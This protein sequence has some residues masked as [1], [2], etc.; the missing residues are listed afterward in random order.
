MC[1]WIRT[2]CTR[3][4]K[5]KQKNKHHQH[6]AAHRAV[7]GGVGEAPIQTLML[8]DM[9]ILAKYAPTCACRR[10]RAPASIDIQ[11]NVHSLPSASTITYEL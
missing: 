8:I 1:T 4:T 3:N 6:R 7:W 10:V 2:K 11:F 9:R 5:N